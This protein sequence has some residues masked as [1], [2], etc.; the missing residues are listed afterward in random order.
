ML[1][2]GIAFLAQKIAS[3]AAETCCVFRVVWIGHTWAIDIGCDVGEVSRSRSLINFVLDIDEVFLV[4]ALSVQL[5]LPLTKLFLIVGI[6]HG[7]Y[8]WA[9]SEGRNSSWW[10]AGLERWAGL[11]II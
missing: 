3:T 11:G 6:A 2:L 7:K 10:M 5:V 8:S 1:G 4:S 9:T